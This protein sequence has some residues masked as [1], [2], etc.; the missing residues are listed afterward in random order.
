MSRII[1]ARAGFTFLDMHD[2]RRS[3]DHPRSR[4]VYP[5]RTQRCP[6]G[7]G[8]SPL[9]RGLPFQAGGRP[10]QSGIIPA[11]AGFTENSH[12]RCEYWRD[13]PRSRGV[14]CLRCSTRNGP[15]G[16]SPLARGLLPPTVNS[17]SGVRIIPARAGFTRAPRRH[18]R[19]VKDHPRSRG[20][21]N[22]A[23]FPYK[24]VVGSSPLA[25][26]LL[27]CE[28]LAYECWGIIPARAGFTAS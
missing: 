23:E 27:V 20:V 10:V 22:L 21:Y 28:C 25:R 1:P 17:L 7:G 12:C 18:P 5:T 4:G 13:H 3:Q 19:T 9:A 14:Y 11:R 26:G 24:T 15:T 16:S 8:S 6:R 2:A